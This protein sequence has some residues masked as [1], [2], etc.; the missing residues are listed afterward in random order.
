MFHYKKSAKHKRDSN[1]GNEGGTIEFVRKT[2][3][4]ITKIAPLL[5]IINLNL[6]GLNFLIKR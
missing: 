2:Q 4:K 3:S 6:N 1:A 5:L